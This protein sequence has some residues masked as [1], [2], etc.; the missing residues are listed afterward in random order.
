MAERGFLGRLRSGLHKTRQ[1]LKESLDSVFRR[2]RIDPE[3]LEE[4]EEA[5]IMAD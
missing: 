2:Q 5:L 4:L 3:T 1:A